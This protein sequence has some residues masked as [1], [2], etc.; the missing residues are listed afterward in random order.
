MTFMM[1]ESAAMVLTLLI[2][3]EMRRQ[4]VPWRSV[5]VRSLIALGVL[6]GVIVAWRGL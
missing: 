2:G 5:I 6:T 1:L 3:W 4:H